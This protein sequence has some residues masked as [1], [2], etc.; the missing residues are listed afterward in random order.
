M[1]LTIKK[2]SNKIRKELLFVFLTV[3]IPLFSQQWERLPPV[4][5]PVNA[6]GT[7]AL[8]LYQRMIYVAPGD[9]S[10]VIF[11]YDLEEDTWDS[12]A[13]LLPF[14]MQ[15]G[16]RMV[17]LPLP[18][19]GDRIY[20]VPGGNRK[21]F[22]VWNLKRNTIYQIDSPPSF[23]S[24]G[25]AMDGHVFTKQERN[26]LFYIHQIYLLP[27]GGESSFY[28]WQ[29]KWYAG[30]IVKPYPVCLRVINE[31]PPYFDWLEIE[32]AEKYRVQVSQN[33]YFKKI[34]LDT[35]IVGKT[36]FL[37]S[38]SFGNGTFYW[39]LNW[40]Y[41][42]EWD[43][44]WLGPF[45]FTIN[46]SLPQ[47]PNNCLLYTTRPSFDWEDIEGATLYHLQISQD[48]LFLKP[49]VNVFILTSEFQLDFDLIGKE[50]YWR[51]RYEKDGEWSEWT[52]PFY[53]EIYKEPVYPP[54]AETLYEEVN[55]D[56]T[57]SPEA[58]CYQFQIDNLPHF[59]SPIIDTVLGIS[60]L[61]LKLQPGNYYWRVRQKYLNNE[62]QNWETVSINEIILKS[63]WDIL[64]RIPEPVQP[65]G[66]MVFC[67]YPNDESQREYL[68]DTIYA[69][70]GGGSN[71]LYKYYFIYSPPRL[72]DTWCWESYTYFQSRYGT[73]LTWYYEDEE[74][75]Y[76]WIT[77]FNTYPS[78]SGWEILTLNMRGSIIG[79]SDVPEDMGAG[80]NILFDLSEPDEGAIYVI[81]GGGSQSFYRYYPDILQG[82]GG[83]STKNI[84][85]NKNSIN[86]APNPFTKKTT[87]T[88]STS[89]RGSLKLYDIT[90]KLIK[91]FPI[92]SGRQKIILEKENLK[93]GIYFLQFEKEKLKVII[94]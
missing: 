1:L 49:E 43:N 12:S 85:L 68:I 60:N 65:G 38:Q 90:G 70:A 82:G 87:I 64:R 22:W 8:N 3:F 69:T 51:Y 4:P 34:L 77:G 5:L 20:F 76:L 26:N 2:L 52:F 37:P 17:Y 61:K 75:K 59:P 46:T 57:A 11:F 92:I 94:K 48:S 27:G 15:G 54:P 56:W 42:G 7:M 16:A 18:I 6:G 89:S 80:G 53:F 79:W 30:T 9:S 32:G 25:A 62:W 45:S 83:Q 13:L 72:G 74:N 21:E 36:E 33:K 84:M 78:D 41:N 93:S 10:N 67:D 55:F 44:T 39:R 58:I 35:I 91:N 88:I 29:N 14:T 28:R 47:P 24:D 40:Y 71:K 63:R 19:H 23:V 50:Y 66:A 81:I 73:S 86:I 31:D